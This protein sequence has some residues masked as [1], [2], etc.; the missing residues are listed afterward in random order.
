VRQINI[1]SL[2]FGAFKLET[3]VA[4]IEFFAQ[5]AYRHVALWT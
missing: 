3:A 2:T 4:R 5:V 1:N